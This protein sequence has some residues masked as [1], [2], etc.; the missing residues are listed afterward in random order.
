MLNYISKS[1]QG[2]GF[3]TLEWIEQKKGRRMASL[4]NKLFR[5]NKE[6]C[7]RLNIID[8]I[9]RRQK[10][11]H[12]IGDDERDLLTHKRELK[13]LRRLQREFEAQ[14]EEESK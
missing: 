14:I 7:Y 2:E 12:I 1:V 10:A 6:I 4:S 13:R 8:A 11:A 9:E 3:I 5:I